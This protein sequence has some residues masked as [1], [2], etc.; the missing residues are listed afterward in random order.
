MQLQDLHDDLIHDDEDNLHDYPDLLDLNSRDNKLDDISRPF[1]QSRHFIHDGKTFKNHDSQ[2]TAVNFDRQDNP[3]RFVQLHNTV[4]ALGLPNYKGCRLPLQSNLQ[5]PIWRNY[6]RNYEDRLVCEFLEFGWPVG[7]DYDTYSFPVSQPRNHNGAK[8]FTEDLDRYLKEQISRSAIAGPFSDIPFER[9]MAISPLNTVDKKDSTDRRVI[10]DLSWPHNSSVNDGISK[11]TYEGLHFDL[12]FP[13]VDSIADLIV[14]KGSGCLIYKCDL[15][16][17]Y[18]QFPVDPYD[19]PLLGSYWKDNYYFDIVLPMGLRS[20]AMA[21]QRIT[22]AITYI[23]AEHGY[24]VVNYLDDFQGVEEGDKAVKG[25]AYLQ[26]LLNKLGVEESKKKACPPSTI[27]TCLG[28][29]FD[30]NNMTISVTKERLDSIMT[31][32]DKWMYKKKATK[33]ELQSLIGKLSFVAKC[34]RQSRLFLT[35]ILDLLRRLSHNHHHINISSECKKDIRWWRE[36]L[37][38]YNGVSIIYTSVWSKPDEIF[39]TDACLTGCGGVFG[40]Q[41]FHQ[42]FPD[43]ILSEFTSIHHLECIA[44][45]VA[46]RLWGSEWTGLR[47]RVYCDNE[48]IVTVLNSGKTKDPLL[49]RCLRNIW[50]CSSL[51]EFELTALHLPG[52]SNRAADYLSRW[53]CDPTYSQ[54]FFDVCPNA[55]PEHSNVVDDTL[56]MLNECL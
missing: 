26:D 49:G 43:G 21:C 41:F 36:F 9:G 18:R 17:A 56:F 12:K 16:A 55:K 7:Y 14:K 46:T 5:I 2:D 32:L 24:T 39:S 27:V 25:F 13:T 19:Y 4:F 35:R 23:C 3:E 22:N 28:V 11:S 45:L 47:I 30:T 15:K 44:I 6:L 38:R 10:L 8:N 54:K 29:E 34:V 53:H 42:E 51:H 20:A 50:L 37:V 1:C 48:A 33:R 52:V 31:L 40:S